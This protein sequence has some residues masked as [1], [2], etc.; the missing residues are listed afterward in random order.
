MNETPPLLERFARFRVVQRLLA[1][2]GV[3]PR[4]FHL[5]L[6]LLRTLSERQEYMGNLGVN[7]FA[8]AYMAL[9]YFIFIGL[10]MCLLVLTGVTAPVYLLANLSVTTLLLL[11]VIVGEAANTLFN[12]IEASVLAHQPVHNFTY[13]SAKIAHLLLIVL[14]VVPALAGPAAVC[15]MFLKD[16]RWFFPLTHI[17]AALL[18]GLFTA[19]LVCALNGWLFRIFPAGRLKSLSLWLQLLAFSAMP[20]I[21]GIAG[22]F[23]VAVHQMQFDVSRWAWLPLSWFVALGLLGTRTGVQQVGWQGPLSVGLTMVVIWLG[24]RG[25]SKEYLQQAPAL[26]REHSGRARG[27]TRPR[28]ITPLIRF[29]TGAP[30]GVAAFSFTSLLMRRD[31]QFRRSTFICV[32]VAAGWLVMP[33]VTKPA[34][35][36]SPLLSHR[37]SPAYMF[38]PALGFMLLMACVM[39][40]FTDWHQGSWIFLAA[41]LGRLRAFARGVYAA[42]WFPGI[43]LPLVFILPL[44]ARNWGWKAA[45]LFSFFSAAVASF[46]LALEMLLISGLPFANPPKASRS[47]TGLPVMLIGGMTAGIFAG[48]QWLVFQIWWVAIAAGLLL[49]LATWFVARITLRRLEGEMLL[50]LQTLRMGPTKM[51][52]E[53]EQ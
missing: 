50:N 8:I 11:I 15:G 19:F 29:L 37:F 43:A 35:F 12:P 5:F 49:S 34:D 36:V 40:T 30:E 33:V 41:P 39:I 48:L 42:L 4:Q 47:A 51:F 1:A 16:A 27:G 31:W 17:A 9:F 32:I 21:G 28:L 2:V 53:M 46:Y 22:G 7:R 23:L 14:Y 44:L 6:N 18:A 52:Q 38:P 20:F 26:I 24:L 25:F 13:V 3:N 10:P 45:V